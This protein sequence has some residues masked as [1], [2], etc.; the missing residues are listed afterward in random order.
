MYHNE[1]NV[2]QKIVN[3]VVYDWYC[4]KTVCMSL[5]FPVQ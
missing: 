1:I 4:Y 2:N 5:N 3:M